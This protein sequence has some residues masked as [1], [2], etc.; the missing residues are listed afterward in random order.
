VENR[1]VSGWDLRNS[2]TVKE[3]ALAGLLLGW[4]VLVPMASFGE[5]PPPEPDASLPTPPPEPDVRMPVPEPVPAPVPVPG[6]VSPEP[7][8][9]SAGK[10]AG[11]QGANAEGEAVANADGESSANAKPVPPPPDQDPRAARPGWLNDRRLMVEHRVGALIE[12]FDHFFGDDRR[13]AAESSSTRFRF[14]TF[15]RTA[16]DKTFSWGSAVSAAVNLPRLEHWLGNARLLVVGENASPG[17]PLAPIGKSPLSDDIAPVSP[18]EMAATDTTRQ[19]GRTELRFDVVRHGVLVFD[20]TAGIN[21]VWPPVPFARFRTHLR[22]GLG[23]GYVFRLTQVF[24]VELGGRGAGTSTDL[25]VEQ[26]VGSTLRLRWEG[27]GLYAEHTRGLESS[28]LVGA[29]WKLHARTGLYAGVGCSAF[30][31]PA[32]GLDACRA[33][34]GV[35]Q[36]IWTGWIFAEL[37]PEV[38]WT[39]LPG[40]LRRQVLAVT[41]RLEVLIDA[42]P[43][44]AGAAP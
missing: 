1:R 26:F 43:S 6:P 37:E 40:Q 18:V 16:Q 25:L 7:P 24:F 38:A 32:P 30:G 5:P 13:L 35:R 27:H 3:R 21:F 41:L 42:R 19:R 28:S 33:W 17:A 23:E 39:R 8:A 20:T 22:L 11:R 34:N 2:G 36:D 4:V 29:E 15:V 10:A 44:T 31:T 12:S 14:K 9:P